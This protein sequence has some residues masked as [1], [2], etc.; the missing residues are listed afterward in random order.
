VHHRDFL[1]LLGATLMMALRELGVTVQVTISG[2]GDEYVV[3]VE[4]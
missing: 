1:T 4:R 3:T 2:K